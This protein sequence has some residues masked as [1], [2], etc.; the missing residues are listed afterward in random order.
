[1]YKFKVISDN[2]KW[3]GKRV[4][5]RL[6]FNVPVDEHDKVT[7][8]YRILKSLPTIEFLKKEGARIII[9]SH[10][11]RD[12]KDSLEK[13][14]NYCQNLFEHT[15][16]KDIFS[17]E[18]KR[19]IDEMKNGDIIFLENLRQHDGEANSDKTF[20]EK[21]AGYGDIYVNEAFSNCHRDH[22]SMTGLPK[23]LPTYAGLRLAKEVEN[24]SK[25]FNPPDP[26][27][28]IVGGAKFDTKLSLIKKFSNIA[29]LVFL[30]GALANDI[31]RHYGFEIG[32]SL[33]S[34]VN[35]TEMEELIE[36]GRVVT[37]IDVVVKS[38]ESKDPRHLIPSDKIVDIGSEAIN[39]LSKLIYSAKLVIWN[40]PLGIYEEGYTDATEK[41]AKVIIDSDAEAII[42]GGDTAL[43]ASKFEH[44][45][46]Q[47]FISTGGGAMLD[48]LADE[49]LVALDALESNSR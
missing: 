17:D 23:M 39:V 12:A 30:G 49:K 9:L 20:I 15:F 22:S 14:S 34:E 40:G 29:N 21:L 7:D 31:F 25:A 5:L 48:F 4:L 36:S 18:T 10:I 19:K 41:I 2:K 11:G 47:V 6:D 28:L 26:F 35:D 44:T 33:V 45:D 37:P 27:L 8:D 3:E 42:G 38:G 24:L 16:L 32:Q 13:V 46:E 1:M 43:A